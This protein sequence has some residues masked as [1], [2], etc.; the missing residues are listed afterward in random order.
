MA[1][2]NNTPFNT[3]PT[4]WAFDAEIGPFIRE[5]TDV[6]FQLRTRSGGDTDLIGEQ[7]L[8]LEGLNA[9]VIVLNDHVTALNAISTQ[10]GQIQAQLSRI[11]DLEVL[12]YGD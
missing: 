4:A 8:N 11:D 12:A 7:D 6:I 2:V 5:L 9:A 1:E 3:I 10:L